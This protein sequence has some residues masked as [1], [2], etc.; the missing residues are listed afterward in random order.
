[1]YN[2]SLERNLKL[3]HR[4]QPTQGL[5]LTPY[6]DYKSSFGLVSAA[7]ELHSGLTDLFDLFIVGC[8]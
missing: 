6:T 8:L 5:P 3:N 7:P 4:S 2:T 1:M